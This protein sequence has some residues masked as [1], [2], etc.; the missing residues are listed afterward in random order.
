MAVAGTRGLAVYSRRSAR[1]RLFGD[2]SQEREIA[3]QAR[4]LAPGSDMQSDGL[5]EVLCSFVL[6]ILTN[7]LLA[8][9]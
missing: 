5:T 4:S 2:V 1:W 7:V 9:M 8:G 6:Q 3:V